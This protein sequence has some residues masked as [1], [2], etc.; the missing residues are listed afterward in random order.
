MPLDPA[1]AVSPYLAFCGLRGDTR[2]APL[3]ADIFSDPALPG[4]GADGWQGIAAVLAQAVEQRTR[5]NPCR[6]KR[7]YLSSVR[8]GPGRNQ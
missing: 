6:H 5:T 1:A 2:N 8:I 4:T 3:P 7:H